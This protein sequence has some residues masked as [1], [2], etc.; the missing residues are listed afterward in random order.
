MAPPLRALL[1]ALTALAPACNR[2]QPPPQGPEAAVGPSTHTADPPGRFPAFPAQPRAMASAAFHARWSDGNAELTSY[3]VITPRYGEPR[4]AELVLIY[5]TEPMN[6]RTWI[7][8]DDARGPDRVAVLKLNVS[9]KFETGVY[10]YSVMTSVFAPLD[11]W[12]PARFAPVKITL[13]AQEWCGHVFQALWP[14]EDSVR[15]EIRSYFASEGERDET[16]PTR[17]GTLYED[18]LL[19]QLRELDGPFAEGGLWEGD[20]VPSLWRTRRAHTDGRPVPARIARSQ[21]TV[22]GEAVH[23]FVL[24][25]GS[26]RRTIDVESGGAHQV[27]GWESSEGERVRRRRSARLPYWQLNREAD[28]VPTRE[29]LGLDTRAR[30]SAVAA[31]PG[32][33]G[34]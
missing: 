26:Y 16:L 29:R 21:A 5:V 32:T 11:A 10:P 9:L 28:R 30:P 27:I 15:T 18:A 17:P 3:D 22:E 25:S 23:R 2:V 1:L 12:R 8:D 34:R 31:P 19:I 33:A 20:L 24:E 14:G 6:R 13:T 7:K 4:P